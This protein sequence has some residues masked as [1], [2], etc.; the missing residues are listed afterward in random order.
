MKGVSLINL[1]GMKEISNIEGINIWRPL[2]QITKDCIYDFAHQFGVPYFKDTTPEWSTRG[3]L[4]NQVM[5]SLTKTYGNIGEKL[6]NI[7]QESDEL[8]KLLNDLVFNP[9]RKTNII[10][11]EK[12]VIINYGY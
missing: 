10:R 11:S 5:P 7:S 9:F 4:R 1:S 2:L 6:T 3:K 12:Q 8:C